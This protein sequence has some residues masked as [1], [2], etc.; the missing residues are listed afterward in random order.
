MRGM[1]VPFRQ[2]DRS[3]GVLPAPLELS[4][5]HAGRRYIDEHVDED[6]RVIAGFGQDYRAFEAGEGFVDVPQQEEGVAA[7]TFSIG[8]YSMIVDGAGQLRAP[9]RR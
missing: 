7:H 5:V 4:A 9:L 3:I 8:P 2:F 6:G 1:A